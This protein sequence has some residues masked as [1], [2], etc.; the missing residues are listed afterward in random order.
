MGA[1]HTPGGAGRPHPG[2][3]EE[4][5]R[6]SE[7]GVGRGPRARRTLEAEGGLGEGHPVWPWVPEPPGAPSVSPGDW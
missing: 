7:E 3:T 4:S 5:N 1:G 6:G 2:L